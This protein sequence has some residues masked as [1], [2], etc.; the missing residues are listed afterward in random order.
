MTKPCQPGVSREFR[1]G[2]QQT[3]PFTPDAVEPFHAMSV[4]SNYPAVGPADLKKAAFI[5]IDMPGCRRAG[6]SG[7]SV[8]QLTS[9]SNSSVKGV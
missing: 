3:A 6:R 4:R 9:W 1:R 7:S 2:L 5:L 8:T